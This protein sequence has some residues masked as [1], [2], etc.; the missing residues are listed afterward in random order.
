MNFEELFKPV[1]SDG[2]RA[3]MLMQ[4]GRAAYTK[5]ADVGGITPDWDA[6][7]MSEKERWILTARITVRAMLNLIVHICE[8]V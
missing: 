1:I 7:P 2:E 4:M 6:L 3:M 5:W 8:E